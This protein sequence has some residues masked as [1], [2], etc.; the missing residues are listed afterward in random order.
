MLVNAQKRFNQVLFCRRVP[1][2]FLRSF[3]GGCDHV[4]SVGNNLLG[5][6]QTRI[7]DVDYIGFSW[8]PQKCEFSDRATCG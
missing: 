6:A 1:P 5:A 2:E 8:K 3:L 4:I 7:D